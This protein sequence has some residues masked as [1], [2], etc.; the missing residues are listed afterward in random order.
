MDAFASAAERAINFGVRFASKKHAGG[1]ALR[2]PYLFSDGCRASARGRK[3]VGDTMGIAVVINR[4]AVHRYHPFH[5][6]ERAALPLSRSLY[7]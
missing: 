4:L 2:V 1:G 5:L 6:S 7:V 3:S